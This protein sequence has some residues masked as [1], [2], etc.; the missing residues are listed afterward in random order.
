MKITAGGEVRG[1]FWLTGYSNTT[2]ALNPRIALFGDNVLIMWEEVTNTTPVIKTLIF[3]GL[4]K[5]LS[6]LGTIAGIRLSPWYDLV[7]L[8]SKDVIWAIPNRTSDSLSICRIH[9]PAAL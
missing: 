9:G 3:D 1:T 6:P 7:S 8:P 5:F 2:F 4:G